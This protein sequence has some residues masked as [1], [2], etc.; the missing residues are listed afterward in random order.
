MPLLWDYHICGCMC[1]T[2]RKEFIF[3]KP[4]LGSLFVKMSYE[5]LLSI[6][7]VEKIDILQKFPPSSNPAMKWMLLI[8]HALMMPRF[9][10]WK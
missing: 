9:Q 4:H 7:H 5:F 3:I 6:R 8:T 1:L 10:G 2:I